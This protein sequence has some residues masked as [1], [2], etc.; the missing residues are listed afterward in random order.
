MAQDYRM[1]GEGRYHSMFFDF[2]DRDFLVYAC[3]ELTLYK[4]LVNTF[5]TEFCNKGNQAAFDYLLENELERHSLAI[6]PPMSDD[7]YKILICNDRHVYNLMKQIHKELVTVLKKVPA[8]NF[9]LD[10]TARELS[11]IYGGQFQ[12][13]SCFRTDKPPLAYTPISINDALKSGMK[14]LTAEEKEAIR[15][16]RGCPLTQELIGQN[17]IAPDYKLPTAILRRPQPHQRPSAILSRHV[18]CSKKCNISQTKSSASQR[19]KK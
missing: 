1:C 10:Y 14:R 18:N 5:Y 17:L 3:R 7:R 4:E 12:N 9:A 8:C 11:F 16:S 13:W 19:T 2:N 15:T 6:Y